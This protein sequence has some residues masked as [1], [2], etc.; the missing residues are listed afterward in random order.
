MRVII[1][2]LVCA[3]TRG[4]AFNL[5]GM[6]A[7]R[8]LQLMTPAAYPSVT[9]LTDAYVVGAT[10]AVALTAYVVMVKTCYTLANATDMSVLPT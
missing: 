1:I 7:G 10:I 3:C 4:Q 2:C 8:M 6:L 5:A 9:G